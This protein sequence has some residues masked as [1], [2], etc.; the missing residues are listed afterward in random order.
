[1]IKVDNSNDEHIKEVDIKLSELYRKIDYLEKCVDKQRQLKE[2]LM[3]DKY[4]T[5][6]YMKPKW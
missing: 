2:L 4:N 1:M 5:P 3:A 6:V